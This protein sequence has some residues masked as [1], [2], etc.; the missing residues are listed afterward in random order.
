MKKLLNLFPKKLEEK[1]KNEE[2]LNSKD[3]CVQ[4]MLIGEP[5][6]VLEKPV[7]I[8]IKPAIQTPVTFM[9]PVN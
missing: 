6:G 7:Q 2:L 1:Q 9:S 5:L 8:D 4:C 3:A